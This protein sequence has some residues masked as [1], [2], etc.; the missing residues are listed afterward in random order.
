M[1]LFSK[2]KLDI[3]LFAICSHFPYSVSGD[4]PGNL[5]VQTKWPVINKTS[6]LSVTV[7]ANLGIFSGHCF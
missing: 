5:E 3:V 2:R 4:C 6:L 1:S 7:I